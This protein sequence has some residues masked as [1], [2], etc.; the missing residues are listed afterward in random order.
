MWVVAAVIRRQHRCIR[1]SLERPSRQD[2]YRVRTVELNDSDSIRQKRDSLCEAVTQPSLCVAPTG[3]CHTFVLKV[4]LT[5]HTQH[6][7]YDTRI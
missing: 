5:I 2:V 6:N 3:H 4:M 1:A 7:L